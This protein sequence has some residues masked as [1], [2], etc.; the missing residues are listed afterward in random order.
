MI[1]LVGT[2]GEDITAKSFREGLEACGD[3]V[4]LYVD[5]PGGD[6]VESNAMSLAI[7]EFALQHPEKTYT[8]VLGSLVASAAANFV[9]KLPSC[10]VIKAYSDTLVM[11]HS[12]TATIDGNPEQLRDF[13][14]MMSLVNENVI[15]SL[16]TRTSLPA[17]QIKSAFTSGRELWLDG[18]MAMGCGLVS[19]LIDKPAVTHAYT[20][21]PMTGQIMKMV[22]EY[23]KHKLEASASEEETKMDE[24]KIEAK[25]EDTV[26]TVEAVQ[27]TAPE[28]KA[29]EPAEEVKKELDEKPDETDFEAECGRLK[30]ECE[31]LKSE[32]TA[33]KDELNALKAKYTPSAKGE[34]KFVEQ[35]KKEWITLVRALNAKKLPEVEYDREYVKL[36]AEHKAEFEAYIKMHSVR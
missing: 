10:F 1:D 3:D 30:S 36:K 15:R 35:D 27:E 9:S 25:A 17:D 16:M 12:C 21:T 33:L 5:S 23:R 28:A 34:T 7:S 2:I 22:A 26:E 4:E 14:T 31:A 18:D 20:E 6:V 11:F 32:M 29:E 19:E 8:C 13:A 24:E